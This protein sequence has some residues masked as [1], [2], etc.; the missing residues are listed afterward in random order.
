MVDTAFDT[1]RV[2][3]PGPP[4]VG[5]LPLCSG[6]SGCSTLTTR[7][8]P[9]SLSWPVPA[10]IPLSTHTPG[11]A[12]SGPVHAPTRDP[13]SSGPGPLLYTQPGLTGS[14]VPQTHVLAHQTHWA[15][16]PCRQS[17]PGARLPKSQP[18]CSLHALGSLALQ[19]SQPFCALLL[20]SIGL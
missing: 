7:T 10:L 5:Y 1:L 9:A 20:G 4:M 18:A 19:L 15:L 2:G 12:S 11:P 14:R 3:P 16:L 6:P 8:A 13:R 17:R